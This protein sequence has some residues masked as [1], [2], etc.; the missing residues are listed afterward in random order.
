M[1]KGNSDKNFSLI[2]F[3]GAHRL[4]SIL[5]LFDD[6]FP[7][8]LRMSQLKSFLAKGFLLKPVY[9]QDFE[10]SFNSKRAMKTEKGD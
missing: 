7:S 6:S 3:R 5:S 9:L 1:E 2:P 10:M 8:L 4:E